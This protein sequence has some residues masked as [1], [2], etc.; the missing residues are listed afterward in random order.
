CCLQYSQFMRQYLCRDVYFATGYF[1]VL[2]QL[3]YGLVTCFIGATVISI[4]IFT[5]FQVLG[6]GL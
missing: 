5:W 1:T 3:K 6:Y 4:S 2:D